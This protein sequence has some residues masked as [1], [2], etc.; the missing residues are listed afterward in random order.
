[1]SSISVSLEKDRNDKSRS[2]VGLANY[3]QTQ[4]PVVISI[5]PKLNSARSYNPFQ[6]SLRKETENVEFTG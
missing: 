6:N 5:L 1:M 4:F 3:L 2:T